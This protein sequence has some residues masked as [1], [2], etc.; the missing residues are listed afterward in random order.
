MQDA[1]SIMR[2]DDFNLDILQYCFT[3]STQITIKVQFFND[4]VFKKYIYH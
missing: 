3:V 1:M 2:C 4:L